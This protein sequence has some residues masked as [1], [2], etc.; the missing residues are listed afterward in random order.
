MLTGG[1]CR[2]LV[3]PYYLLTEFSLVLLFAS[4]VVAAGSKKKKM[5]LQPIQIAQTAQVGT[6]MC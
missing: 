6:H 3:T 5:Y 2:P 4:I 1:G